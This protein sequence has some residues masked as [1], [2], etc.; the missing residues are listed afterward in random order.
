MEDA[1]K[2]SGYTG[3]VD[4][5]LH[6][7]KEQLRLRGSCSSPSAHGPAVQHDPLINEPNRCREAVIHVASICLQCTHILVGVITWAR[8]RTLRRALQ[9]SMGDF[10]A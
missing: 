4:Q 5:P 10:R 1:Q 8:L 7:H 6:V 2:P 3:Q 9:R